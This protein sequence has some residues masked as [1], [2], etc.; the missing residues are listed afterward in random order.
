MFEQF[1]NNPEE[2]IIKAGAIINEQKATV[3]IQHIAYN[4]LNE[5][6]DTTVFTEPTM[7]GR[8]GVNTMTAKKHLYDHI[9]YDS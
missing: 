1:S 6:Y 7:K 3:I 4:K 8:L 2:F 5:V 9:I